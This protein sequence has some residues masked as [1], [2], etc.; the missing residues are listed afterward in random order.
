MREGNSFM[1]KVYPVFGLAA[2]FVGIAAFPD[3]VFV[4][5]IGAIIGRFQTEK[6]RRNTDANEKN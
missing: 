2:L 5:E 4:P 3:S 6:N 1:T